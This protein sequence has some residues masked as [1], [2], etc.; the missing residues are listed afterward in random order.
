MLRIRICVQYIEKKNN[1]IKFMRINHYTKARIAYRTVGC[2][3]KAGQD[4]TA[5]NNCD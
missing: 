2:K 3:T 1:K 4:E 5:E